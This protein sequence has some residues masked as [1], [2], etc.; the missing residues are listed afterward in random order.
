M[1]NISETNINKRPN[2]EMTD[3]LHKLDDT[4]DGE[5]KHTIK[6]GLLGSSFDEVFAVHN[7]AIE[8]PL[9]IFFRTFMAASNKSEKEAQRFL[10]VI[11]HNCINYLTENLD[12]LGEVKSLS[13]E[14]IKQRRVIINNYLN[15]DQIQLFN[16]KATELRAVLKTVIDQCRVIYA[17]YDAKTESKSPS[18]ASYLSENAMV[19]ILEIINAFV[20]SDRIKTLLGRSACLHN[21]LQHLDTVYKETA[22]RYESIKDNI[23]CLR[24]LVFQ[25]Y[26][27]V[28]T[29]D[30]YED[31]KK[32]NVLVEF[33]Y[34]STETETFISMTF[35]VDDYGIMANL[36]F[37]FHF[38]LPEWIVHSN[39]S[40]IKVM[41][42]EHKTINTKLTD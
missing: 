9:S 39:D 14:T 22:D 31:Y 16:T 10:A 6:L 8:S 1:A 3:K 36:K 13:K 28:N 20:V 5:S 23:G 24:D 4:L 33:T 26:D 18:Y 21:Y 37:P 42:L 19:N 40:Y 30:Q 29:H 11:E 34:S 27:I 38:N 2:A 32:E 12:L 25:I 35:I 7:I 15:L 17:G 41:Q